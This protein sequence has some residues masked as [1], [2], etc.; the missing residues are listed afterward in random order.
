MDFKPLELGFSNFSVDFNMT[1]CINTRFNYNF[2]AVGVYIQNDC[3]DSW[4]VDNPMFG[5]CDSQCCSCSMSNYKNVRL[6]YIPSLSCRQNFISREVII[7][8]VLCAMPCSFADT[9]LVDNSIQFSLQVCQGREEVTRLYQ[10]RLPHLRFNRTLFV[11]YSGHILKSFLDFLNF[12]FFYS[13]RITSM[14]SYQLQTNLMDQTFF[15]RECPIWIFNNYLTLGVNAINTITL[16]IPSA[17]TVLLRVC[18][19]PTCNIEIKFFIYLI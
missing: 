17:I 18:S 16:I 12:N 13:L 6:K 19:H 4:S 7:E 9:V 14:N 2:E 8:S 15:L 3:I 11:S 1:L 5:I 10:P